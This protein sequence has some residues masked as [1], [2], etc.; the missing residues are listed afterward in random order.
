MDQELAIKFNS[1]LKSSNQALVELRL[2]IC[3]KN[4]CGQFHP[5]TMTCSICGCQL[6]ERTRNPKQ[7]CPAT[8][9]YW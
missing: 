6:A 3:R 9:A 4:E 7:T 1:L 5:G 8:P 2:K